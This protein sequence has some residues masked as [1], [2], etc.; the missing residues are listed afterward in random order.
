M[1]VNRV[2]NKVKST[3]LYSKQEGEIQVFLKTS[4][5]AGM[6]LEKNL[7][8]YE[9]RMMGKIWRRKET[10]QDPKDTT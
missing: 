7:W 3:D 8:T 6:V 2:Y 4:K 10:D 9:T 5:T 1:N